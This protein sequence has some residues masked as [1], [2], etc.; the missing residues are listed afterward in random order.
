[1]GA[2]DKSGAEPFEKQALK[3]GRGLL[4]PNRRPDSIAAMS[5]LERQLGLFAE[6][7]FEAHLRDG[8]AGAATATGALH[9]QL[10]A[11]IKQQRQKWAQAWGDGNA[12]SDAGNRMMQLY[13]LTSAMA[14]MAD[15]AR[16]GGGG[17]GGDDA[18][19]LNRWSGWMLDPALFRRPMA[20]VSSRLK[21]ATAAAVQGDDNGLSQQLERIDRDAPLVKLVRRCTS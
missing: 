17:E 15:I 10:L 2:L 14:D 19:L 16:G 18:D 8:D 6:L 12:T 5:E 4:D 21:L 1:M 20:D 7:P 11:V 9:A 13:R 3:M